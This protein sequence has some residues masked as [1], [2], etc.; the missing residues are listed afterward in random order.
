MEFEKLQIKPTSFKKDMAII[1]FLLAIS[2][3]L[4]FANFWYLSVHDRND[5]NYVAIAGELRILSQSIAKN[6]SN[7]TD[8]VRE[9]FISLKTQRDAFTIGMTQLKEGDKSLKLPNTPEGVRLSKLMHLEET[10]APIKQKVDAILLREESLLF[11][12]QMVKNISKTISQLQVSYDEVAQIL[13]ENKAPT[14]QVALAMKQA[15]ISERI[16]GNIN[17]ILQAGS[18]T[19]EATLKF[20]EDAKQFDVVLQGMRRGNTQLNITKVTDP[21]ARALLDNISSIFSN[22]G[23]HIQDIL[24]KSNELDRVNKSSYEIFIASQNLL[25]Q[26]TE[27]T[28]AYSRASEIRFIGEPS[29]YLIGAICSMLF[30][31]LSYRAYADTKQ[32]LAQTAA[33][34]KANR[35]AVWR[36]LDELA[37][38]A[39]GDLTV[40]ATVGDDITGAI[41]E[42]VNYA[43]NALRKLASTINDTALSVSSAAAESQS[44]A[45]NLAVAAENQAKEI[46]GV[47][48]AVNA[49]AISIENVSANASE[50]TDVAESSVNIAKKGVSIVQDT[51]QGMDRIKS[52]IQETAKQIKKLGES[53]QEI[54][55]IVSLINDIAEQT[56][57]LALN[58]S[59]QAA[60]AGE[61]GRGFAVVAEEVQRLAERSSGATKKIESLVKAIQAETSETVKSMEQ[62]TAEVVQG[63]HL[64]QDAGIALGKIESVSQH[65]ANLIENISSAAHEQSATAAKI[66]SNMNVIQ[67]ITSQTASGTT[68]T[69]SSIGNLAEL[70]H[71]LRDSVAG[72]KLPASEQS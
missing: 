11:L 72:F 30:I 53:S 61:A 49:M 2:I 62:T 7:A 32:S 40:Q 42:S 58:A 4:M 27:L 47:S 63:A 55:D 6:A 29:G 21:E 38:L 65:L 41:A 28:E 66:S 8:G 64:T 15:L 10:W 52:Q 20:A 57:I 68:A 9:A 59:I 39:D 33:Q 35:T 31:W 44:T 16:I 37:N 70:A 13:I 36:L 17:K 60:M 54:G 12:Y 71:E 1:G 24:D 45:S 18:D 25:R 23:K 43:I 46:V 69:A 5:K 48:A 51:I 34:H 50:S 26:A 14:D 19:K 22:L 56:N 3:L 67:E